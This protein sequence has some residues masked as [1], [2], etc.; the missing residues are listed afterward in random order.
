MF[1]LAVKHWHGGGA[2]SGF[3]FTVGL[4][5]MELFTSLPYKEPF[6]FVVKSKFASVIGAIWFERG[7]C[8]SLETE[9]GKGKGTSF[10][11]LWM[12]YAPTISRVK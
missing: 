5:A 11:G 10:Y 1:N 12:S 3:P 7:V 9:R 4:R 8:K 2:N 6:I